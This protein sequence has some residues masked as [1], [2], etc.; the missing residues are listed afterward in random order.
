MQNNGLI[1]IC[2]ESF[3]GGGQW[4]RILDTD[5]SYITQKLASDSHIN[6]CISLKEK[7]NISINILLSTYKTKYE[8]DYESWY[9]LIDTKFK[10]FSSTQVNNRSDLGKLA[11]HDVNIDLYDWILFIRPDLK[12]KNYFWEIFD[13]F[14]QELLYPYRLWI[15]WHTL[16]NGFCNVNDTM[17]FI[18]KRLYHILKQGGVQLY[19]DGLSNYIN[20]YNLLY[21]DFNFMIPTLHDSDSSKDYNPLYTMVSRPENKYWY[22]YGYEIHPQD[23]YKIHLTDKKYIFND[24]NLLDNNIPT[25]ENKNIKNLDNVWEWWHEDIG[26]LRK[27]HNLIELYPNNIFDGQRVGLS[28]HNDQTYWEQKENEILMYHADRRHSTTFNKVSEHT[29]IGKYEF[30]PNIQF[31]L[32]KLER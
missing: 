4:N 32:R 10:Y 29:Y 26:V 23:K 27:F 19:H 20:K 13:P 14:C 31:M 22:S 8:K 2:G 9:N 3:R 15:L 5:Q 18:P 12:L 1:I 6:F 25:H 30:N 21:S 11:I 16:D 28:R 24:W 17:L 7:F